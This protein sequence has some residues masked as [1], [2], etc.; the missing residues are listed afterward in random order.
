MDEKPTPMDFFQSCFGPSG[1]QSA[2]QLTSLE[3]PL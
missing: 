1:P 3:M 2:D